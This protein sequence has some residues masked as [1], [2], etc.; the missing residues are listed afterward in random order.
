MTDGHEFGMLVSRVCRHNGRKIQAQKKNID[1]RIVRQFI[2]NH[3]DAP[4]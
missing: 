1:V 2:V 3:L 4:G